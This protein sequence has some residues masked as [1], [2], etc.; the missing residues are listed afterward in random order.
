M[1]IKCSRKDGT[2][3]ALPLKDYAK[4]NHISASTVLYRLAKRDIKG[5]KNYGKWYIYV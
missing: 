3:K 1:R 2:K 4:I 5:Y